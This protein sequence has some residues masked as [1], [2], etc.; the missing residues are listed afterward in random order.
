MK[1]AVIL[2]AVLVGLMALLPACGSAP[3]ARDDVI[4]LHI[5]ANSDSDD[6]QGM[7][8]WIRD[9]VLKQWGTE[10]AQEQ[11]PKTA[12]KDLKS[13]SADI[14]TTLAKQLKKQGADYGVKVE[15]GEYDFPDKDYNGVI[16]PAGRYRALE[17]KLGKG[18]GHNWWC[19]MFPP[20]CLTSETGEM[21]LDAYKALVKELDEQGLLEGGDVPE[22]PVRSWLFD[23]VADGKQWDANFAEWTKKYWLSGG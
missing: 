12:W 6:D 7:K 17:V 23:K 4:R 14:E 3:A 15:T 18:K 9:Y 1:K 13:L 19:V 20:L 16:F 22:A 10:L 11:D 5:L 21:D 8:L 2:A